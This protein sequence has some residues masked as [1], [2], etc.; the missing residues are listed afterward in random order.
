MKR[1]FSQNPMLSLRSCY[2]TKR[3]PGCCFESKKNTIV[4][5]LRSK[6]GFPPSPSKFIISS[7]FHF[8]RTNPIHVPVVSKNHPPHFFPSI[9]RTH[10]L[11]AMYCTLSCSP[12]PPS[13]Q[14]APIA[15]LLW[16]LL[17]PALLKIPEMTPALYSRDPQKGH[18]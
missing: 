18:L 6:T 12:A 16:C 1:E 14:M 15:A 3:I 10:E 5:V 7:C 11:N 9:S 17:W 13:H 4:F 2:G 8:V